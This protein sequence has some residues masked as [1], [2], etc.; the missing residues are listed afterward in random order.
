[1]GQLVM[2]TNNVGMY[3]LNEVCTNCEIRHAV[4]WLPT[5]LQA[6]FCKDCLADVINTIETNEEFFKVE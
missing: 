5:M 6:K 1:M 3:A 4:V 2:T